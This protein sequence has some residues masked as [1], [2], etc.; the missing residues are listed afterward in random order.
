M[1]GIVTRSGVW[2]RECESLDAAIDGYARRYRFTLPQ[3]AYVRIE[4][5]SHDRASRFRLL[6]GDGSGESPALEP[7]ASGAFHYDRAYFSDPKL[8]TRWAQLPLAPGSYTVETITG[9][10]ALP[11]S[12]ELTVSAQPTPPP[13]YR[14][15][16]SKRR[17]RAHLRPLAGRHSSVLGTITNREGGDRR[18]AKGA[19]CWLSARTHS[20]VPSFQTEHLSVGISGV[21]AST[22]VRRAATGPHAALWMTR[23]RLRPTTPRIC[24]PTMRF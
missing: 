15:K 18:N 19:V 12:F 8:W 6:K 20:R 13:P 1:S 14:F 17:Y 16:S 21:R 3:W 22:L 2:T 7:D 4:S 11:V 24:K 9:G 10:R 5:A 23:L